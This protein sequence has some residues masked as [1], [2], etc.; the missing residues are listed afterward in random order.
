MK[1]F[2]TIFLCLVLSGSIAQINYE[3]ATPSSN[4]PDPA[5]VYSYSTDP[6]EINNY[7][8]VV[9]NVY[10]WIIRK[11]NGTGNSTINK[12]ST[13]EAIANL[14]IAFNE[15]NMFF[16]YKGTNDIRSTNHIVWDS[17]SEYYQ[18]L[19]YAQTIGAVKPDAFNVYVPREFIYG[20]ITNLV[21]TNI[22][23]GA[24]NLTDATFV[25]EFGHCFNLEHLDRA[26]AG[27]NCENVTR[28][29]NN[30]NFNADI[31]GDFVADTAAT[32]LL[33]NFDVN[34]ACIYV[35]NKTDCSNP[36]EQYQIPDEDI[37]NFLM[38]GTSCEKGYLSPGQGIRMREAIVEDAGP[39]GSSVFVAAETDIPSLYEPY[40]GGYYTG[41]PVM[42]TLPLFQPGFDYRFVP[43]DCDCSP[44][45]PYGDTFP[46]LASTNDKVVSKDETD[47]STIFH[48]NHTAI[49]IESLANLGPFYLEPQRCYDNNDLPAN[50]GKVTRFNDNIF[51]A[52]VTITPQ[53]SLGINNPNLI[54]DLPNGLYSIEKE[55]LDGNYEQT[56]IIKDNN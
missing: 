14:N 45:S 44:P 25:H 9:Y 22:G 28:D 11:D 6:G 39:N 52:N 24:N 16:K 32:K 36:P 31:A 55:Y 21:S 51:N 3:C 35:G 48:P 17:I 53:D 50:G 13:L 8:P 4:S 43:C 7:P 18:V 49:K 38:R 54:L 46:Y 42:P 19:N 56:V 12:D 23:V 41:G 27:L 2:I 1:K 15:F 26:S 47:Y 10:F 33:M 29:P 37:R 40:S 30:P 5:G 34:T 20:G